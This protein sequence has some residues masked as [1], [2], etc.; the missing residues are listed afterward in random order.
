MTHYTLEHGKEYTLPLEV[1]ENLEDSKIPI[2]AYQNDTDGI[3]QIYV[4]GYKYN[5]S[6]KVIRNKL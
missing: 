5:F 6:C 1:V 4:K 2:Y 3:P